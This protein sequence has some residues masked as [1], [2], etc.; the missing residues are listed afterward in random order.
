MTYTKTKFVKA[1]F[2]SKLEMAQA[3]IGG[4]TLHHPDENTEYKYLEHRCGSPFYSAASLRS[5]RSFTDADW[6]QW[7]KV[8]IKKEIP[9]YEDIPESGVLCKVDRAGHEYI[10][11]ITSYCSVSKNLITDGGV[12]LSVSDVTP[13]ADSEIK[14]F[15][16]GDPS[17]RDS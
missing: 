2:K 14:Q 16:R 10:R 4:E 9:W 15:L 3:L 17:C 5:G 11:N 8:F 13:L 6:N 7:D 1:N 12:Y